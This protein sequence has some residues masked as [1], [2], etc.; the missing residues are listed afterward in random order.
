MNMNDPPFVYLDLVD[1]EKSIRWKDFL[2]K[3][4]G[5]SFPFLFPSTA[6]NPIVLMNLIGSR[7]VTVPVD[8]LLSLSGD[9]K[10]ENWNNVPPFH[11]LSSPPPPP[12]LNFHR[13]GSAGLKDSK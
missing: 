7:V 11:F 5:R 8:L 4:R 2:A 13:G 1:P 9:G 3:D 10:K 12:L 6:R